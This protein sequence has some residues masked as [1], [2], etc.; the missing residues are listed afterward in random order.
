M[1][2]DAVLFLSPAMSARRAKS[3]SWSANLADFL[4]SN[5]RTSSSLFWTSNGLCNKLKT[6]G[7]FNIY[8][9]LKQNRELMSFVTLESRKIFSISAL[10]NFL[11][12]IILSRTRWDGC[13]VKNGRDARWKKRNQGEARKVMERN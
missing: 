3:V 13:N 12:S 4:D 5:S 8:K 6:N 7:L 11:N 9:I 2:C 1:V 10:L